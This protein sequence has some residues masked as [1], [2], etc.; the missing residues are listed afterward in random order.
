[1]PYHRQIFNYLTWFRVV[2]EREKE[3]KSRVVRG[4]ERENL[5]QAPHSTWSPNGAQS[6]TPYFLVF[7]SVCWNQDPNKVH[8]LYLT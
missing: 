3:C 8:T 2:S 5:N 4:R 6:H 1:M 7:T